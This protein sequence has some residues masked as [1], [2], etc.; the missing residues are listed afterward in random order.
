MF[1]HAY[2]VVKEKPKSFDAIPGPSGRYSL[3]YIGHVFHFKPFGRFLPSTFTELLRHLRREHGPVVR[4]RRGHQWMV[5]LFNPVDF[6]RL[7][8]QYEKYP[9]RP[10][11][12]LMCVYAQRNNVPL[13]MAFQNNEKWIKLRQPIQELMLKPNAISRHF[14]WIVEIANDF[15]KFRI[16]GSNQLRD[17]LSELTRLSAE[18][19][20]M[21]CYNTRLGCLTR[22]HQ[23]LLSSIRD[24][25]Y[26]L[27]QSFDRFPSYCFYPTKFYRDFEQSYG[28]VRKA[29][30]F[31][32]HGRLSTDD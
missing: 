5:F 4:Q 21:L 14:R 10:T 24:V 17:T 32:I 31:G 25:H 8:F 28:I 1:N 16:D 7:L 15:I 11:P 22:D 12:S 19:S 29:L 9:I 27:G 6:Q 30:D 13:S 2:Q 20:G 3:P 23:E 18:N 26:F